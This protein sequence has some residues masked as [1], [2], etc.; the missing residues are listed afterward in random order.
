QVGEVRP[1]SLDEERED[2]E[3][4]SLVHHFVE[5]LRRVGHVA[6]FE[7]VGDRLYLFVATSMRSMSRDRS[8]NAPL[9]GERVSLEGDVGLRTGQN[10]REGYNLTPAAPARSFRG[11]GH[12]LQG[13]SSMA[14]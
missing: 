2:A 9:G 8:I 12:R 7:G 10:G 4:R 13:G 6:C 3:A 11:R 14:L 1:L 5:S